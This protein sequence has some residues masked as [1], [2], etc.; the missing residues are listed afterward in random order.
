MIRRDQPTVDF[1]EEKLCFCFSDLYEGNFLF[2]ANGDLYVLDFEQAGFL[3]ISFMTY[4]LIQDRLVCAAI[5]EKLSLPQGNLPGIIKAG[6]YFIMSTH[7][8][9]EYHIIRIWVFI[10]QCWL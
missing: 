2:S 10:N 7:T 1:S 6:S 8:I 5:E 4:A 3:P 9:G